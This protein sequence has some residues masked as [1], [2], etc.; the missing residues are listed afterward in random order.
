MS[1]DEPACRVFYCPTCKAK[2]DRGET[3]FP[4]CSD[5]CRTID[6]GS[7]ADGSYAI[8]GEAATISE[9]TDQWNDSLLN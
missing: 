7:W 6:L 8:P 2:V 9:E 3:N 5:R 1:A 4:F